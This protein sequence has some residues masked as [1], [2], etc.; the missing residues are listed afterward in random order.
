MSKELKNK[1]CK[2]ILVGLA[3][4]SWGEGHGI[5]LFVHARGVVACVWGR[6]GRGLLVRRLHLRGGGDGW[7]FGFRLLLFLSFKD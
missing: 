1:T 2:H 6:Q 4:V 7:G 5:G 3:L